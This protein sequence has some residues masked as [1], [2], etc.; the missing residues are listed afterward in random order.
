MYCGPRSL[1]HPVDRRSIQLGDGGR[2][3]GGVGGQSHVD[4]ATDVG[5]GVPATVETRACV[6]ARQR[7]LVV[8]VDVVARDGLELGP[9]ATA[10]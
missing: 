2:G 7:L 1:K 5:G 6:V 9:V 10:A 4:G 3:A 8:G